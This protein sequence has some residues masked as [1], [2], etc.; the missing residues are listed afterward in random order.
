M[1]DNFRKIKS[2]NR[3]DAVI[4]LPPSKSITNR[5][6][7]LSMLADGASKLLNYS[8]ADDCQI[9]MNSIARF[10]VHFTK[11]ASELKIK[12]NSGHFGDSNIDIKVGN[13]G[14]VMRFL[15]SVA[16][17]SGGIIR[18][19][20]DQNMLKRPIGDL[21]DT[22][23]LMGIN[24]KTNNGFPPVT[25]H[26]GKLYGGRIKLNS[27]I[28]S[29]FVSSLLMIAP[30]AASDVELEI[31]SN[32]PSKPYIGITTQL[33]KYFGINVETSDNLYYIPAG[34]AYKSGTIMVEAD[35]S[36]ASYFLT[37]A[38]ITG[39][40]II[41]KNL[42]SDSIQGDTKYINILKEMGC[43]VN[44]GE[45]GVEIIGGNLK[46]INVDMNDIPDVV[47]ALA[48]TALFADSPTLINNIRH[49]RY[50]ESDR[51]SALVCE[52]KKLGANVSHS[53][54]SIEIFPGKYKGCAINTYNDH[55]IAMSFAVAGLR[56]SGISIENPGCVSK[57]YPE[58]WNEFEK[59]ENIP[60]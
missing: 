35:A 20:G 44:S 36:S 13:A 3:V 19:T 7:I 42:N 37:A 28:S 48:I 18:L 26:G 55:R 12:G 23:K 22:L 15:C 46:G 47:P 31:C 6:I 33:M 57:S 1:T 54:N 16:G 34:K 60:Q 4:E 9:M 41:L 53:E 40:K 24:I 58:F 2:T 5:G 32:V 39:G 38:A 56:I 27:V 49:L 59:L 45:F 10:G 21:A 25:I 8:H 17:L 29:Q 50:K 43:S 52:L 30:Y 14:T 11:S 51:I